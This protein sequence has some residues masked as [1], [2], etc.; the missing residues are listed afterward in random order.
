ML[1]SNQGDKSGRHSKVIRNVAGR[2]F[3]R[4]F[5]TC[6]RGNWA[7]RKAPQTQESDELRTLKYIPVNKPILNWMRFMSIC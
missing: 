2:I 6:L 5:A 4:G 3:P 1:R 7:T